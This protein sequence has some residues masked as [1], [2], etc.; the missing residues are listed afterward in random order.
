MSSQD[1]A[2]KEPTITIMISS[3]LPKKPNHDSGSWPYNKESRVRIIGCKRESHVPGYDHNL[4]NNKAKF[5]AKNGKT[6]YDQESNQGDV[7]VSQSW[8]DKEVDMRLKGGKY[9]Y[10]DAP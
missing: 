6:Q 10:K 1:N 5:K 7:K 8:Y 3:K 9:R 2:A 4:L